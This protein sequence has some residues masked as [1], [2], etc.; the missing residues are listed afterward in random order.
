MGGRLKNF[1]C[2]YEEGVINSFQ[3]MV[4]PHN[5]PLLTYA[6]A[7]FFRMYGSM[8]ALQLSRFRENI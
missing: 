6:Y 1:K 7:S 2:Y 3:Q 5:F 4:A 8:V